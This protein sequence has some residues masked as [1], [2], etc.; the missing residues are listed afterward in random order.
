MDFFKQE[1]WNGLPFPTLGGLPN[2]GIEPRFPACSVLAGGFFTTEPPL[3]T[4]FNP[5]FNVRESYDSEAF[6]TW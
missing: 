1:Y 4:V 6:I 5:L 3:R 2:P